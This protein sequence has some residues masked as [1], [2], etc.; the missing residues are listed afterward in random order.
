MTQRDRFLAYMSFQDVDRVP[1]MEMRVWDE[2]IT[3]WHGEG[4]PKWVTHFHHLEDFLGLDRTSWGAIPLPLELTSLGMPGCYLHT[5]WGLSFLGVSEPPGVARWSFPI[6]RSAVLVG[7]SIFLQGF[8]FD[9]ALS[10]PR[11]INSNGLECVF[12]C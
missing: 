10:P 6:P 7:A 11:P 9:Q 4:L 2:T 5:S 8:H 3:R 12:G 1:L